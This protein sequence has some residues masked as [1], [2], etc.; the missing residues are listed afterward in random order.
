MNMAEDNV[1]WLKQNITAPCLG[2]VPFQDTANSKP[3]DADAS[4]ANTVAE[5]LDVSAL[6]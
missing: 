6:L 5:L 2:V 4:L 3:Q 1:K